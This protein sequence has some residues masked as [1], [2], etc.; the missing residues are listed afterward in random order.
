[1]REWFRVWNWYG[2]SYTSYRV[3]NIHTQILTKNY[4][5]KVNQKKISSLYIPEIKTGF[6][7][8]FHSSGPPG[9]P[10]VPPKLLKPEIGGAAA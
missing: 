9:G 2:L 10:R 5:I 1:M 4:E 6:P 8:R 7:W 3:H